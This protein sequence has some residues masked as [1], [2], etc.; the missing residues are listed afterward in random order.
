MRHTGKSPLF[1]KHWLCLA[2]AGVDGKPIRHRGQFAADI[3]YREH[4]AVLLGGS[5]FVALH[6][7]PVPV[8]A[9]DGTCSRP[10]V[11]T[12]KTARLAPEVNAASAA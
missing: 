8:R 4:D 3:E 9:V 2:T 10:R 12:T 5:S 7:N 1:A 11:E 6:D